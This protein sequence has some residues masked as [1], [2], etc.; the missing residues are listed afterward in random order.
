MTAGR[1]DDMHLETWASGA[2]GKCMKRTVRG[3][4]I[5]GMVVQ[6]VGARGHEAE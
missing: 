5:V 1:Q 4:H 3:H 6:E 2:A